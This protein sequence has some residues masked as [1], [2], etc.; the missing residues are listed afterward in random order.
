MRSHGY[1]PHVE[2]HPLGF[3]FVQEVNQLIQRPVPFRAFNGGF[4]HVA[5]RLSWGGFG[6]EMLIP[7][8]E[9]ASSMML[10]QRV[11]TGSFAE[12]TGMR[13]RT[14]AYFFPNC[15][16]SAINVC[17][18]ASGGPEDRPRLAWSARF[19]GVPWQAIPTHHTSKP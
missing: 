9:A 15:G 2:H 5:T 1:L 6:F 11:S 18:C 10:S 16:R 4:V 19:P 13:S 7:L 17:S 3:Q 14:L 8:R 12:K